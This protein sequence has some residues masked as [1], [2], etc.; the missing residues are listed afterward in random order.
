M[1]PKNT[2]SKTLRAETK[3]DAIA[4]KFKG[5]MIDLG[6]DLKD[7]SLKDTPRRVAKMYVNELCSGLDPMNFPKCTT[8]PNDENYDQMLVEKDIVI[9]SMCEHHFVP[10]MGVCH[11]AYIPGDRILGLSK[12]HRVAKHF[13]RRP[14]VQERLTHQIQKK[15]Q[16]ILETEDVAVVIEASHLC[17]VIRG[18]EDTKSTTVTSAI[19]G[20]FK[21]S[22]VRHEFFNFVPSLK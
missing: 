15:L 2:P 17:C 3:I 10:F 7:E 12:F 18:V 4:D 8:F 11:I 14:Q 21:K 13:A 9:N 19:G 22:K 6:L 16:E 1:N 5:I 20:V